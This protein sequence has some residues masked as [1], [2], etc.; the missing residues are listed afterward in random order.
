MKPYVGMVHVKNYR[1][2]Q[3]DEGV[4]RYLD[5]DGGHRYVGCRLNEGVI[6]IP[7]ALTE[8]EKM[9]YVGHL[10]IEY[11]GETNP[12][13]ALAANIAYLRNTMD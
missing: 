9:D 3:Q 7:E 1:P 6:D 12:R 11:Q 5:S 13:E 4:S 8:L 10:L 2:I